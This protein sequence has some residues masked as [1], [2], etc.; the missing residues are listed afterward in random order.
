VAAADHELP[1]LRRLGMARVATKQRAQPLSSERTADCARQSG[2][3]RG[4]LLGLAV[5]RAGPACL[6]RVFEVLPE[7]FDV[8]AAHAD[9][10][11]VVGDD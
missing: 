1:P 4:S 5:V 3:S 8:L 10:Q 6:E 7:I 11:E 9:A 2:G